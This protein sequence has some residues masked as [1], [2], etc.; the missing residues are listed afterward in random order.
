[1]VFAWIVRPKEPSKAPST[2]PN[3]KN[4]TVLG[5]IL[6]AIGAIGSLICAIM[7]L[8]QLFKKEGAGL[9]ILGIFC[10]IYTYIWG[11]M[12]SKELGL[13]KIMMGWT[14][15]MVLTIIG[16]A[17][18]GMGIATSPEV[19]KMI[20]DAQRQQE[21]NVSPPPAVETPP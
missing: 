10:G 14:A 17:L 9:G 11:W 21:M 18:F 2:Q 16:Q 13:T 4:M 20:Q 7:V 19:Q 5:G 8:I 3:T 1:M 15:A 12:K 6:L